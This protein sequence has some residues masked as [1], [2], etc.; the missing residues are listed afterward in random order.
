MYVDDILVKSKREGVHLDN[1]R[2]TFETLRLYDM[3]LNPSK[4]VF[5]VA[6]GK[7]LGFMV[8]QR[9]VEANPDKIQAI[10]KMTPPKNVKEIQSL[11]GRVAA[12]NRFVSRVMDKYLPFFKTLKKAFEW[13][14]ECQKAF[15]ELKAYLASSPLLSPS[16]PGEELSLYLAL[17]PTA[18]SSALI[19]KE[20]HIQLLIYYTSRALRGPE[21][22]YP[23]MEKLAFTLITTARKLR[24][25]FQ[26]HTIVVQT[27]K[28]LRKAMNN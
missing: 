14:N 16:K 17:S 2:E 8:S 11:N 20:D 15:E 23:P 21:G 26:V 27:D 1:L 12:L 19:R 22:R 9:G 18:V 3:E 5:G 7:F 28:P 6:L 24:P 25:Y 4:C 13:T 10:L